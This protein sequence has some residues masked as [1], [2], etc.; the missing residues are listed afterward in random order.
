MSSST[1]EEGSDKL[2]DQE[3]RRMNQLSLEAGE[4]EARVSSDLVKDQPSGFKYL[5]YPVVSP[6]L[7]GAQSKWLRSR[8]HSQA[9]DQQDSEVLP[10]VKLPFCDNDDRNHVEVRRIDDDKH[11]AHGQCG[12]FVTHDL[13]P[14]DIIVPYIGYLHSSTVSERAVFQS[15]ETSKDQDISPVERTVGSTNA[16]E[17]SCN[18]MEDD[19]ASLVVIGS[20][21]TSNY[22]LNLYRSEDIELAIDAAHM[23]N[24]ARFCNDY[25]GV[26]AQI[27]SQDSVQR[28]Q[29]NRK[30]KRTAKTWNGTDRP[31]EGSYPSFD[32]DKS[33]Q[34]IPN[35]EFRDVWLEWAPDVQSHEVAQKDTEKASKEQHSTAF[36]GSKRKS[37]GIESREGVQNSTRASKSAE[38]MSLR[39][40]RRN[41]IGMRGVAI[42]VLPVGKSGKRKDGIR[43]GQEILV[44]Y[45]KGF[46]AH[47][48]NDTS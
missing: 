45:G 28:E 43:A 9:L 25:R 17:R 33:H 16:F 3:V 24:E 32:F 5:Q 42:F 12:L 39:Q 46:W 22:D 27:S 20:W 36:G 18:G 13:S 7:T 8:K 37:K 44:S 41:K 29:W 15:R 1:L 34:A 35:A 10:V 48:G 23:G 11:P 21:D 14:G 2:E 38:K 19:P 40:K 47:H 30:K 4:A 26:P 6:Y 31:V